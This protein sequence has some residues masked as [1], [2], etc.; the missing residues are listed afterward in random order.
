[1]VGPVSST[2]VDIY[3]QVH[4]SIA[5]PWTLHPPKIWEQFVDDAC[6]ILKRM[7]LENFFHDMNNLHQNVKLTVE[8]ESN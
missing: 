2:T 7:H 1:M 4:E 3:M 5:I 6:Y 8:D